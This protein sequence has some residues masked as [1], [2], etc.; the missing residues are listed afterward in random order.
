MVY[1]EHNPHLSAD[2]L[3]EDIAPPP[4]PA[5]V[6]GKRRHIRAPK[7]VRYFFYG[8]IA[9]VIVFVAG[10]LIVWTQASSL[11]SAS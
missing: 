8:S 11:L 5:K 1:V 10:A 9:A 2:E 4:P 6:R 7:T 3:D